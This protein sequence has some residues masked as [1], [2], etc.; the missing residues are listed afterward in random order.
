MPPWE[1]DAVPNESARERKAR[2]TRDDRDRTVKASQTLRHRINQGRYQ[3][4]DSPDELYA[5]AA[6]LDS[7]ALAM[8]ELPDQVRRDVLH[9]VRGILRDDPHPPGP[10]TPLTAR[11]GF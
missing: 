9:A 11:D 10:V 1:S 7:A 8:S 3:G 2:Q 6:V 4:L 5:L